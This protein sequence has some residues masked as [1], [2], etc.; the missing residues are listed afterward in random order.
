MNKTLL[1]SLQVIEAEIQKLEARRVTLLSEADELKN[2]IKTLQKITE[3]KPKNSRKDTK[4]SVVIS[5]EKEVI[6]EPNFN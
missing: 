6:N 2:A 5:N 3:I 4:K 1:N